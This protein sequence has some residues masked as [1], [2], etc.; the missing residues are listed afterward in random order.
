LL[1]QLK[2]LRESA[3][4]HQIVD[5]RPYAKKTDLLNKQIILPRRIRKSPACIAKRNSSILH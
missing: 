5:G 4:P 1:D 2:A 3:I